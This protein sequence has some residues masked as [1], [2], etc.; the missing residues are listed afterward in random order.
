MYPALKTGNFG[1]SEDQFYVDDPTPLTAEGA[2][3][4]AYPYK[5]TP[6][7]ILFCCQGL[8]EEFHPLNGDLFNNGGHSLRGLGHMPV[9][10][11]RSTRY[12]RKPHKPHK[13]HAVPW[14]SLLNKAIQSWM[15]FDR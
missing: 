3:S 5:G 12:I 7:Y 11:L 6:G 13:I 10:H 2:K 9:I 4:Q 14:C 8:A 15:H 1:T